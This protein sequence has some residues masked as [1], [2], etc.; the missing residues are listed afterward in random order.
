MAV[1]EEKTRRICLALPGATEKTA[2]GHPTFRIADKMFAACGTGHGGPH[3][4]FAVANPKQLRDSDPRFQ[5][6]PYPSR[7]A[8]LFYF[9]SDRKDDWREL[10]RLL[11]VSWELVFASLPKKRQAEILPR[12]S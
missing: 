9:F 10:E 3:L 7:E 4:A 1:A 6:I 11:E 8:W 12:R 2:W 5:P